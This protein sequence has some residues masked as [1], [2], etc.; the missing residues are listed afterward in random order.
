MSKLFG[1]WLNFLLIHLG[2]AIDDSR[3]YISAT[4]DGVSGFQF[5]PG[6]ILAIVA[7]GQCGVEEAGCGHHMEDTLL[8]AFKVNNIF[9]NTFRTSGG[10]IWHCK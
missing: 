3:I 2:R 4:Q 5:Y 6:P 7:T 10:S 1:F 9:K 8:H